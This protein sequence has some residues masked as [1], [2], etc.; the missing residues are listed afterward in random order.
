MDRRHLLRYR[1][2]GTWDA[3]PVPVSR[4]G[5]GGLGR[6]EE[7]P[8]RRRA[9][10]WRAVSR[11]RGAPGPVERHGARKRDPRPAWLRRRGTH[12]P[13][14]AAGRSLSRWNAGLAYQ[15]KIKEER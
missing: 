7:P 5:V 3:Y 15:M 6:P 14:G 11:G 10:A 8:R 1:T 9:L 4:A 13:R 12:R 2:T